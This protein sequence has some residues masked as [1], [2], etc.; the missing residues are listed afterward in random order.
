M[1]L[2]VQKREILGKKTK[3][4]RNKGLIPAELYGHNVENAHLSVPVKEFSKIF[5]EA[6]ES[7]VIK[8]NIENENKAAEFN[9]LIHDIE[10]NHI[11][12]EI[13]HIDFY[14]IKMDEKIRVRVPLE[15]I[16][17]SAV[18]KTKEG[19]LVKAMNEI[20]V[21]ALPGNLPRHI[22]VDVGAITEIGKSILVKDLNL[23][24]GVR[25]L[26]DPE[27]VV[28]T[29]VEVAEEEIAAPVVSVED[30]KVESEEKKKER[31]TEKET[32]EK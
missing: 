10:R 26:V 1:K 8:L 11:T 22:Q 19:L 14:A 4:L 9:V 27:T 16:G 23:E 5:K 2:T 31:E 6:G 13:S 21:E 20:E 25:I 3:F 7:T 30:V 17:E 18:S 32:A 28:A 15:F 24:K 12:D 29:A